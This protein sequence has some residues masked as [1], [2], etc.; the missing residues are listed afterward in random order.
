MNEEELDSLIIF[1][2]TGKRVLITGASGYLANNLIHS[3][4][5]ICCTIIRLSRNSKLSSISGIANIIDITGN[6]CT[7]E[8]WAQVLEKIDIV[9]HFAAQT[10]VYVA[11]KNPL[12]DLEINVVPMLNLLETCRNKGWKPIIMFSGTVTQAGIPK[13]LPVNESHKDCP[14]TIY[15]LHKLMAENYLKY[16]S[17]HGIVQGTILRL[18]NVYGPGPK[19]SSADRGIINMMMRKALSG[20]PLTIYGKGECLRDYIYIE[21]VVPAFLK[22]PIHIKNL[23]SKHFVIGSGTGHTIA[24]AINLV[25]NRVAL[26]TGKQIVPVKHIEPPSLQSSIEGRNF[27]A[28]TRQFSLI[29]GW[30]P[31]YSLIDGIDQTLESLSK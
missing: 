3:L 1:Y 2:F 12:A 4:K 8:I 5:H 13:T 24:Q 19:S 26:K 28:D 14:I 10:S 6:I 18:A 11:D 15:D 9:Y 25:A 20:E 22:A 21:D 30:Y 29:T 27:V 16:Y 17:N 7:R 31:R 23:N